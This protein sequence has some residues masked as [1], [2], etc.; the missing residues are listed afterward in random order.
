[1]EDKSYDGYTIVVP[2]RLK[3]IECFRCI[4]LAC[5]GAKY[6]RTTIFTSFSFL[7]LG[8]HSRVAV[9][10]LHRYWHLGMHRGC[11]NSVSQKNYRG[12]LGKSTSRIA[13]H[14]NLVFNMD[15]CNKGSKGTDGIPLA[16]RTLHYTRHR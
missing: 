10:M 11:I 12:S 13:T 6:E 16:G 14:H 2:L 5:S 7:S 15:P 4:I 1:M 9:S 3:M 8:F